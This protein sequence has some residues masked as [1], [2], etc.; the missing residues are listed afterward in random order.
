MSK[1]MNKGRLT[2]RAS[3]Y[4]SAFMI[5]VVMGFSAPVTKVYFI[6]HIGP[7]LVASLGIVLKLCSLVNSYIKQSKIAIQW[8]T[9]L[10]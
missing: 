3:L 2:I 9:S 10:D 4:I 1:Y 7:E 8:I 6:S 5:S